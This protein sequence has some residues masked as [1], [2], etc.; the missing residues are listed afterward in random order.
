MVQASTVSSVISSCTMSLF[1]QSLLSLL[2]LLLCA[3]Y[4]LC[5]PLLL[6]PQF[7]PAPRGLDYL[8]A[9]HTDRDPDLIG[10][11]NRRKIL[12]SKAITIDRDKLHANFG[13]T[14]EDPENVRFLYLWKHFPSPFL[15]LAPEKEPEWNDICLVVVLEDG[16]DRAALEQEPIVELSESYTTVFTPGIWVKYHRSAKIVCNLQL[17]VA[18]ILK[19][20]A[21]SNARETCQ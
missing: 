16:Y 9:N 14:E 7:P 10:Q 4:A 20:F 8:L 21:S 17:F 3:S 11:R 13:S 18:S 1:P 5:D 2:L 19:Y 15:Y 12:P 6:D